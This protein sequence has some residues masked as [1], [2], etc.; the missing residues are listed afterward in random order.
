M[1]TI[2]IIVGTIVVAIGGFIAWWAS[3]TP[4]YTHR[5]RLVI[6]AEV[7]GALRTGSSVIEVRMVDYKAGLPHTTG[8]RSTV[9]GEAVFVDLGN[10]KHVI[11]ILGFGPTGSDDWI[12]GLTQSAFTPT[13]PGLD[14]PGVPKLTGT[15]PLI[16]KYI[17]TLVT[18]ADLNDPKSARVVRPDEFE[19]V[20]G[21][22][23]R[24]KRAYVEMVPAG[25]PVT[26]G[27][28]GK[29]PWLP[30]PRYL[31]GQ[32]ACGPTEPHCLH[33]GHFTRS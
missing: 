11:A 26:R 23:V 19:K 29:M 27:I 18:F 3:Q 25:E 15:A 24:F 6:E 12:A 13:H 1:R 22:G 9:R 10:G 14:Y 31:S 7:G 30:H 33:G 4:A 16:G 32:F 17:P 5:F 2:G 20:F 8:L 28:E 21:S